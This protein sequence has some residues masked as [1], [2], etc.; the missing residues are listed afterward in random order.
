MT[1]NRGIKATK[2][3]EKM[4]GL[5]SILSSKASLFPSSK[6]RLLKMSRCSYLTGS[7]ESSCCLCPYC[8]QVMQKNRK[9]SRNGLKPSGILLP[10]VHHHLIYRLSSSS[11]DKAKNDFDDLVHCLSSL[12][13]SGQLRLS[14]WDKYLDFHPHV[15]LIY[16]CLGP[17][18]YSPV[19]LSGLPS[20]VSGYFEKPLLRFPSGKG[21]KLSGLIYKDHPTL[22]SLQS[23]SLV[24]KK[25]SRVRLEYADDFAVVSLANFINRGV[26]DQPR[27]R[28]RSFGLYSGHKVPQLMREEAFGI[29]G[30]DIRSDF[31]ARVLRI[32]KRAGLTEGELT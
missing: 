14:I 12:G 8:R 13:G 19:P 1:K 28:A 32:G 16:C 26:L 17:L 25:K 2:Y 23:C 31:K 22:H 11:Q 30:E 4:V 3:G 18:G 29:L 9:V 7:R 5:S 24:G 10:S 27:Y 6:T 20:F 15:H 21:G